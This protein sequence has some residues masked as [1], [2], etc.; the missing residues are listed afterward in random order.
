MWLGQVYFHRQNNQFGPL[1]YVTSKIYPKWV[2]PKIRAK[3]IKLLEENMGVNCHDHGLDNEFL[4]IISK[5]WATKKNR[6]I[7]FHQSLYHQESERWPTEWEKTFG[8]HI[9]DKG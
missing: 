8:N 4:D 1:Q 2:K 6:K 9:S 7:G 3:S 5:S